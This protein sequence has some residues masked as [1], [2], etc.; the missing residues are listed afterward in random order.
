MSRFKVLYTDRGDYAEDFGVERP[1]YATIDAEIIDARLDHN[2]LD[3]EVFER[4]L[5]EADALVC[6]RV[7][8]GRR[9]LAAAPKLKVA[10]RGGVG[11]D[12]FD[13][14]AFAER[15]I[16]GCNVPDYGS[17]EVAMHALSLMLALRRRV[18]YFD[19]MLRCGR[20]RGWPDKRP[21]HRLSTQ[22]VG[23]IG[24]GRIGREFARRAQA[25][26]RRVIAYDPLITA[27][28]FASAGV[29]SVSLEELLAESDAVT[30]HAP[31]YESTYHMIGAPQLELMKSSAVLVNTARGQIVDQLALAEALAS[32]TIEGAACDVWEREPADIHHPLLACANFIGTP[33]IAGHSVE[34]AIDS[35]TKQAQEVVRVL[36]G[37]PPRNRVTP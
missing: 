7:P 27:A 17:E 18:L 1:I 9:A 13:M 24:L 11:F 34:G 23:I 22:T 32:G 25:I 29:A 10:V 21:I 31:L 12:N 19:Q 6:F 26:F 36:S 5:A 15:G 16:P 28:D 30:I 14:A 35:R 2:A 20:W 3:W 4:H 37:Q 33:H 8:I